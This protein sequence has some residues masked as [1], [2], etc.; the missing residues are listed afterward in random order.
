MTCH[1]QCFASI[2]G[3]HATFLGCKC[4]QQTT[5]L[6]FSVVSR[7]LWNFTN[8]NDKY[9][10]K[11]IVVDGKEGIILANIFTS[12]SRLNANPTPFV[13]LGRRFCLALSLSFKLQGLQA[14]RVLFDLLFTGSRIHI[15]FN[16]QVF[17]KYRLKHNLIQAIENSTFQLF[18]GVFTK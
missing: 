5:M 11:L 6:P 14:Q 9:N 4:C 16:L 10:F 2:Q 7:V 3:H 17:F 15:F 18:D 12:K 1:T 13:K 8:E